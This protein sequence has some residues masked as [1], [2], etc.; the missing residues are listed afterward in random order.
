MEIKFLDRRCRRWE[1]REN[2][3]IYWY[4]WRRRVARSSRCFNRTPHRWWCSSLRTR[5]PSDGTSG[6]CRGQLF[7]E[8]KIERELKGAGARSRMQRSCLTYFTGMHNHF[9]SLASIMTLPGRVEDPQFLAL[10]LRLPRGVFHVVDLE[11]IIH[12]CTVDKT[13]YA[14]AK[15]MHCHPRA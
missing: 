2:I 9:Q 10:D 15:R 11:E 1:W 3:F 8:K 6:S 13:R 12:R 4:V 7:A 5:L 14:C